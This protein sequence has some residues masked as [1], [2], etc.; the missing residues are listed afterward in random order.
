RTLDDN[1]RTWH[2]KLKLS[3]WADKTTPKRSIGNSPYKLVYGKEVVLPISLEL[4]ALELMKQLEL[5]EF[6]PMEARYVELMELEEIREYAVHM[7]EKDQ[8]LV[9]RWFDKK[10]RAKTFQEGNL[11]LKW[12]AD[13]AKPGKHSKFDAIWSGPYM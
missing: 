7:I 6:K 1:Q 12:D 5:S 13:Q 4:P 8:A 3:L 9:K 11:V 2:T 10:A